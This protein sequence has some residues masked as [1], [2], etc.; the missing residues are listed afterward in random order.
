MYGASHV[1]AEDR[2]FAVDR[3]VQGTHVVVFA[4]YVPAGHAL[5]SELLSKFFTNPGAHSMHSKFTIRNPCLHTHALW[6]AEGTLF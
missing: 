2:D 1:H 3:C 6:L 4:E 5:H